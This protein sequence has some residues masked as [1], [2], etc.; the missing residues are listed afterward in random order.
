MRVARLESLMNLVLG[1]KSNI[2]SF[3]LDG[4][5]SPDQLTVLSKSAIFASSNNITGPKSPFSLHGDGAISNNQ[6]LL[7]N[8][9]KRECLWSGSDFSFTMTPLN[10]QTPALLPSLTESKHESTRK[11]L[12]AMLPQTSE[13]MKALRHER[14]PHPAF[15][16]LQLQPEVF[17]Q[18]T[19]SRGS[20]IEVATLLVRCTLDSNETQVNESL[21]VVDNLIIGDD[22]YMSTLAGLEFCLL[23]AQVYADTGQVHKAWSTIHKGLVGAQFIG[24]HKN[25]NNLLQESLWW[26]LYLTDSFYSLILGLSYGIPD[27]HCNLVYDG[28]EAPDN[29]SLVMARSFLVDLSQITC[30]VIDLIQ[31]MKELN[32]SSVLRVDNQLTELSR[33][34]PTEFWNVNTGIFDS[35]ESF[36]QIT[37]QLGYHYA[38]VI[39]HMHFMFKSPDSSESEYSRN[40]CLHSAGEYLKL[41]HLTRSQDKK[42]SGLGNVLDY[43]GYTTS[44]L[45]A[46][47][48]LGYGYSGSQGEETQQAEADWKLVTRSMD[49]FKCTTNQGALSQMRYHTLREL[50]LL[51][52]ARS[53]SVGT[54]IVIPYFG[55]V[56]IRLNQQSQQQS[57]LP[58][59]TGTSNINPQSMFDLSWQTPVLPS[60]SLSH[61]QDSE[62]LQDTFRVQFPQLQSTN[63]QNMMGDNYLD[64]YL[65]QNARGLH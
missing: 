25:R 18:Q 34:M 32:I 55:A 14:P 29:Q 4:E 45:I 13:L 46:L 64:P 22:I 60:V 40:I 20:P 16:K 21:S 54:T 36:G 17:V 63:L 33:K 24:I 11:A 43:A 2:E 41:Y 3:D 5:I 53:A 59:T 7:F 52:N 6:T 49:I 31:D 50:S 28:H 26:G 62:V 48:L 47:R 56:S 23:L 42:P 30:K 19:I 15:P 1:G 61:Q 39:L 8:K 9:R 10:Q 37:G 38:K 51:R 35:P 44:L 12:L 57:Q 27:K 58:P 65:S